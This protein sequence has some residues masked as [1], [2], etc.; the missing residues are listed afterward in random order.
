MGEEKN[1]VEISRGDGAMRR[2]ERAMGRWGKMEKM[3]TEDGARKEF[4]ERGI[5][6]WW[7]WDLREGET[8][9]LDVTKT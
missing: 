2:K 8:E 4:G 3:R 1:V 5:D 9:N 6:E 7:F